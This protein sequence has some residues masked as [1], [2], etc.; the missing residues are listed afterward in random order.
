MI[1][2]IRQRQVFSTGAAIRPGIQGDRPM[3]YDVLTVAI[4]TLAGVAAVA[5]LALGFA[6]LIFLGDADARGKTLVS[7]GFDRF[8]ALVIYASWFG[9]IWWFGFSQL[10]LIAACGATV[11]LCL[12]Y[13]ISY[14][15]TASRRHATHS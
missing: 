7:T 4:Y 11:I 2:G 3:I 13:I 1:L 8:A 5:V 10:L 14:K 15:T 9:L 6:F 12:I